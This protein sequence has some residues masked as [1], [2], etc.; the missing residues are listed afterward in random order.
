MRS[1]LTSVALARHE[2][3]ELHQQDAADDDRSYHDKA[4]QARGHHISLPGGPAARSDLSVGRGDG[5]MGRYGSDAA[6]VE[7]ELGGRPIG[8]HHRDAPVLLV[9]VAGRVL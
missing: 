1:L 9:E 7:V 2:Q 8:E 6:E 3:G 5:S 4:D